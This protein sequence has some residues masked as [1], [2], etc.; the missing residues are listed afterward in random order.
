MAISIA[1]FST[2]SYQRLGKSPDIL[3]F[4]HILIDL[5]LRGYWGFNLMSIGV[6]GYSDDRTTTLMT[7]LRVEVSS[8]VLDRLMNH[9]G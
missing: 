9:L 5:M 7:V 6:L 2:I 3:G 8:R 1:F 4:L